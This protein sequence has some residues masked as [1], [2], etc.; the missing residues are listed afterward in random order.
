MP[1]KILA[2]SL[3]AIF[4]IWHACTP[5]FFSLFTPTG[6]EY[7]M[8]CNKYQFYGEQHV[9]GC[10]IQRGCVLLIAPHHSKKQYHLIHTHV[11]T[12]ISKL[13]ALFYSLTD[14]IFEAKVV[15]ISVEGRRWQGQESQPLLVAGRDFR[16]FHD[17]KSAFPLTPILFQ[18]L[19]SK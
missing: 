17:F 12:L 4:N 5:P 2:I 19:A 13:N 7:H 3:H 1:D 9:R 18:Q 6:K 11:H 14:I 15:F 16:F 10:S 8:E